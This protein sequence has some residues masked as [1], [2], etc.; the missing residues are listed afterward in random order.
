LG[1]L[2]WNGAAGFTDSSGK[3]CTFDP[4]FTS[5]GPPALLVDPTFLTEFLAENKLRILWTVL[6]E[7]MAAA[8]RAAPRMRYSRVHTLGSSRIESSKPIISID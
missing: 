6:A 4:S 7:K 5:T 8:D 2:R 3:L 1:K